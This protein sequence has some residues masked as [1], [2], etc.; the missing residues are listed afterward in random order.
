M[1]SSGLWPARR[2]GGGGGGGAAGRPLAAPAHHASPAGCEQARGGAAEAAPLAPLGES[3]AGGSRKGGGGGFRGNLPAA[4]ALE[5]LGGTHSSPRPPVRPAAPERGR[6][7][8]GG[9]GGL[10]SSP[11]PP[12][13]FP[14][15]SVVQSRVRSEAR[16]RE[17][18]SVPRCEVQPSAGTGSR[19][20]HGTPSLAAPGGQPRREYPASEGSCRVRGRAACL[21]AC[22]HG[23]W[24]EGGRMAERRGEERRGLGAA[25]ASAWRAEGW[26]V[27]AGNGGGLSPRI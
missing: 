6:S 23:C 16:R 26:L 3:I 24:R 11:A 18:L 21:P 20:R 12:P 2:R 10:V 13:P 8:A 14:R 15:G 7:V 19:P 17:A 5:H 25:P 4:D 9:A 27:G 1:A 22:L